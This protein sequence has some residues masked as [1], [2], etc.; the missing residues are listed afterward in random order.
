MKVTVV[1]AQITT[2]EDRIAGSLGVSQLLLLALPIFLNSGIYILFPPT[3]HNAPYKVTVMIMLFIFCGLMSI[4]VKN[5]IILLWLVVLLRY[6]FRPRYYVF[7]KNDASG[8]SRIIKENPAKKMIKENALV[9]KH[10]PINLLKT[11]DLVRLQT[12]LENPAANVTYKNIRGGLHVY[13][14]ETKK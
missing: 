4:R 11:P 14:T 13:I 10:S 8:R 5:K 2:I 7:D 12:I 6:N 9:V 3:M 1:P